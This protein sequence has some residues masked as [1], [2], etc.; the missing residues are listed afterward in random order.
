MAANLVLKSPKY[1][2]VYVRN[3]LDVNFLRGL[4]LLNHNLVLEI[5]QPHGLAIDLSDMSGE[6]TKRNHKIV[7]KAAKVAKRVFVDGNHQAKI[8]KKW[9]NNIHICPPVF[10][11]TK[12]PFSEFRPAERVK[13]VGFAG[14][15]T[16]YQAL[17]SIERAL[18][19]VCKKFPHIHAI[20]KSDRFFL[21]EPPVKYVYRKINPDAIGDI[22]SDTDIFIFP[23][24]RLT[25][26]FY[27]NSLF[28][29]HALAAKKPCVVWRTEIDGNIF[30]DGEDM[31]IVS[32]E[33][34][35]VEK[36][37][38]LIE[39][40]KVRQ[41]MAEKGFEKAKK[42]FSPDVVAQFYIDAFEKILGIH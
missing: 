10:P 32:C 6:K 3:I 1:D 37:S 23:A 25:E 8:L 4:R 20:G 27:G 22:F 30:K 15:G 28:V 34:E 16:D 2:M 17:K 24:K 42:H 18:K 13:A 36:L 12:A 39:N 5:S 41:T 14:T 21:L 35:F 26:D 40:R 33:D 7:E 19:E 29:L 9:N 38:I 11:D 31:F